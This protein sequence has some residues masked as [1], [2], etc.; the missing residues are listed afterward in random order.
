MIALLHDIHPFLPF[1]FINEQL[2]QPIMISI[3]EL[4]LLFF[5][6]HHI[7]GTCSKIGLLNQF[8]LTELASVVVYGCFHCLILP[9]IILT[10][11]HGIQTERLLLSQLALSSH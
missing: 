4:L 9:L 2:H 6:I 1:Q 10:F 11:L 7:V 5:I 8:L 3:L